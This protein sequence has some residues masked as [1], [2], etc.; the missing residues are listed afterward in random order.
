MNL[1]N[2]LILLQHQMQ[3]GNYMSRIV[4]LIIGFVLG[5][6]LSDRV[7]KSVIDECN[8]GAT[9]SLKGHELQCVVKVK[10]KS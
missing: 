5:V 8:N 9:V 4:F 2:Y 3:A 6:Y 7:I 10:P 1:S